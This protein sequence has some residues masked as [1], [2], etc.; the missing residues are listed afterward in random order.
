MKRIYKDTAW[1]FA[2]NLISSVLGYAII[3][4]CARVMLP[5]AFGYFSIVIAVITMLTDISDFGLN[6]SMVKFIAH[7]TALKD[8]NSV[9]AILRFNFISKGIL[10]LVLVVAGI[11]LAGVISSSFFRM[12][13]LATPLRVSFL[14]IPGIF[15]AGIFLALYQARQQHVRR[16][17]WNVGM[18]AFRFVLL[19]LLFLIDRV[20]PSIILVVALYI[21]APYIFTIP[22]FKN[23]LDKNSKP[24]IKKEMMQK[25]FG[26]GKWFILINVCVIIIGR[27]DMFLLARYTNATTVGF[28]SAGYKIAS[29]VTLLNASLITII[30]P[31]MSAFKNPEDL[32]RFIVKNVKWVVLA[33]FALMPFGFLGS[34][35]IN[36]IY[37]NAYALST[38][39][40][41]LL[42]IGF[43]LNI[44][45]SF[46]EVVLWSTNRP[47]LDAWF[48]LGNLVLS[49][50]LNLVL[51]PHYGIL[52]AA[53][54]F[55][56]LKSV[57]VVVIIFLGIFSVRKSI[58]RK[59]PDNEILPPEIPAPV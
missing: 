34:F 43:L 50:C 15:L 11:A 1:V 3:V 9:A 59:N 45:I 20:T 23:I 26:F 27:I 51:I 18:V 49:F 39:P 58:N 22:F 38:G 10:S 57:G 46:F 14:G 55:M 37:G 4:V 52:G 12:P 35:A 24:T 47:D 31:V 25:I 28:Y 19:L 2:G 54:A 33:V 42:Y 29:L 21:V 48:M 7:H 32:K 53:W 5:E 41:H 40:F 13:A 6:T 36:L 8:E 30:Y 17:I 56:I 16:V 44:L